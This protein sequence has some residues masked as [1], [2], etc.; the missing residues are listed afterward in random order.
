[1]TDAR[2]RPLLAGTAVLLTT[3]IGLGVAQLA[4]G[5]GSHPML[6]AFGL[7][8]TVVSLVAGLLGLW[9]ARRMP[10]G[11]VRR[12]RG[13]F[14]VGCLLWSFG[15]G[16]FMAQDVLGLGLA[17]T[18]WADLPFS[19]YY[20]LA[21]V[22]ALVHL[23]GR[24]RAH[25]GVRTAIDGALLGLSLFTV[26]WVLWL[27]G[28]VRVSD[29]PPGDLVVPIAYPVVDVVFLTLTLVSLLATGS[30][31]TGVLVVLGGTA[32]AV[33]DV[34]YSYALLHGTFET[35]GVADF[36]WIVAFAC[37]ALV[38]LLRPER[39]TGAVAPP[40]ESWAR[41]VPYIALL[42]AACAS[43]WRL[44]A[45]I[46]RVVLATLLA[47]VVLVVLRQFL[48]VEDHRRLLATAEQQRGQLD[49]LA[50]VDPLTGL[51]NRRR[52]G[53]RMAGVVRSALLTGSPVVVAFVDLD[54]FK[55]VNDTLGHAA[56]DDL[57]R[58]VAD[59]L[60][61]AVR[62]G[63][64]VARLGGDEF[65]VLVTDPAVQPGPLVERLRLALL[66]PFPLA[67]SVVTA[68]ASTGAVRGE[69]QRMVGDLPAGL[70]VDGQVAALVE[71]LLGSADA[72]MY[73]VKRGRRVVV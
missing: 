34:T 25:V 17:A 8:E 21:V 5:R 33:A 14:A 1:M 44:W 13:L 64:C 73:R 29:S 67:G 61:A 70:D 32:F 47:V 20:A 18:T 40:S 53:E 65:A 66:E 9:A 7:T 68:S 55:A 60:R 35:G 42:P 52:F 27:G 46:D 4:L 39:R 72:E 10:A 71:S 58:G 26:V 38:S 6:L 45:A 48:T 54:R 36:S 50:H 3:L 43:A 2:H 56:G 63:D 19:F 69:P 16:I 15:Q 28:A 51:E 49:T 59:R 22:S 31:R 62:D 41:L 57:L 11:W 37:F 30:S 12:A 23:R 24:I